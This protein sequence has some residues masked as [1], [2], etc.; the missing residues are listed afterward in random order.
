MVGGAK[1]MQLLLEVPR[2]SAADAHDLGLVN[3]V[4]APDRFEEEALEVAKRLA[5]LPRLTLV[6][7]KRSIIAS[8]EN[9]P[10]YREREQNWTR[11]Y[12][13]L[14]GKEA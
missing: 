11:R 12:G 14:H 13:A 3:H 6:L 4:T 1:T 2:L 10:T 8:C 7:L 5:A 9:L